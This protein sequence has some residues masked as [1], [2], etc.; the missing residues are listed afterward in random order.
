MS[1]PSAEQQTESA[2]F[3]ENSVDFSDSSVLIS[4]VIAFLFGSYLLLTSTT[5]PLPFIHWRLLL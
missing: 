5:D 3:K 2:E 1:E 4:L